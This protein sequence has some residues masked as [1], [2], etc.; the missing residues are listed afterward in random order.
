MFLID[1]AMISFMKK[2]PF[3]GTT[4]RDI[5]YYSENHLGEGYL[6]KRSF[7]ETVE[8]GKK[9]F[10]QNFADKYFKAAEETRRTF[11]EIIKKVKNSNVSQMSNEELA[12]LFW[13]L[14]DCVADG[15]AFYCQSQHEPLMA[16]ENRI[17]EIV[18]DEDKL[19]TVVEP[20]E[21]DD[22]NNGEIY[23]YNLVKDKDS[24]SKDDILSYLE[25]FSWHM[26]NTHD[27]DEAINYYKNK[28]LDDKKTDYQNITQEII[29]S[30][31][32]HKK[33]VISILKEFNND[34]LNQLVDLF[35]RTTL[36][37]MRLKPTWAGVEFLAHNLMDEVAKRL[38]I[39]VVELVSYYR[40]KEVI[41]ALKNGKS[42]SKEE[43]K[44][45]EE[46]YF[47]ALED[48]KEIFLSGKKAK[49]FAKDNYPELF[50]ENTKEEI[51]GTI[52]SKGKHTGKV[53]VILSEN[54]NKVKELSKIF[55]E[56]DVL[57]T[58]MTQPNM[59]VLIAK[60]GAIVTNE[61]GITSHAAVVSREFRIPCIV[62]T[63]KATTTFKDEDLVEVDANK[64]IVKKIK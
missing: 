33:K 45:R 23:W 22:I 46:S 24:I 3:P 57:V 1:G 14:Q 17:R 54:I 37:R 10:N 27:L 9:F 48:Y 6:S 21:L 58:D 8:E 7:D 16:A 15:V 39:K 44:A 41:E 62:G 30:K 55:E 52:V 53:R 64:G 26:W 5:I 18:K 59:M 13:E 34:E 28:F 32:R 63:H 40:I 49:K 43:L 47:V 19:L 11:F 31:K 12:D 51:K 56:G 61:G 35:H 60:A 4:M 36:G 29:D 25:R 50:K 42:L 38:D 2:F 20:Y